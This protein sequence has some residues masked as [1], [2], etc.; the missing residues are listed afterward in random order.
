MRAHLARLRLE[1]AEALLARRGPGDDARAHELLHDA[2]ALANE[3]G[4]SALV[5]FVDEARTARAEPSAEPPASVR[6]VRSITL[7][8]EGEYWTVAH[9]ARTVRL[10]D[11]RGLRVLD[12]LLASPGQEFHVLQ[13]ASG[14]DDDSSTGDAGVVLD[15]EAVQSY[16]TRL[17]ELREELEE[18][19][20]FADRGR[21][22][23]AKTEIDFLTQELARAVGLG[24]RERRAGNAAERARTTVQKRIREAIR[25]IGDELPEVGTHLEQTIRTGTFC[26]YFPHGRPR[27]R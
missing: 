19:E 22:E 24:G 7:L 2:R 11:S 25:R 17:L 5:R 21:S 18:A 3:L 4:Q 15:S 26:G 10:K 6:T 13:L 23:R 12:Q 9:G 27:Q 14:A 1:L 16:R 20:S 8:R